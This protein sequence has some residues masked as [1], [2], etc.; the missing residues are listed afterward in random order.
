MIQKVELIHDVL[1]Q[2]GAKR[3]GRD[4]RDGGKG[5]E[6]GVKGG[7]EGGEVGPEE[8]GG[9]LERERELWWQYYLSQHHL[10][11][12]QYDQVNVNPIS[13]GGRG[14]VCSL[15]QPPKCFKR[16]KKFGKNKTWTVCFQKKI[17]EQFYTIYLV[18]C[19]EC[20]KVYKAF[21]KCS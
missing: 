7:G 18:G 19:R 15:Q 6:E 10:Y 12:K 8:D 9:E 11:A 1:V 3:N 2:L 5:E 13:T 17:F 14:F 4:R 16:Q 20:R 21:P